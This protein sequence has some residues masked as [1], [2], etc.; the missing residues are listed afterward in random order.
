MS[1]VQP[2]TIV[3]PTRR[4]NPALIELLKGLKLGERIRVTQTVRVGAKSWPAEA[5]GAFPRTSAIRPVRA[6]SRMP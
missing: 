5:A 2:E 6:S 4:L 1:T 3:L